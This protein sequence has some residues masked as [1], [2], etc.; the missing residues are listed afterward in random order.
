MTIH[1]FNWIGTHQMDIKTTLKAIK[2]RQ[3]WI[4]GSIV[5]VTALLILAFIVF[6]HPLFRV[7]SSALRDAAARIAAAQIKGV[8]ADLDIWLERNNNNID[9]D[10]PIAPLITA[11]VRVRVDQNKSRTAAYSYPA[12]LVEGGGVLETRKNSVAVTG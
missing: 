2:P 6:I 7:D 11:Q 8:P 4:F 1:T 9:V 3:W 5:S 10:I 12:V